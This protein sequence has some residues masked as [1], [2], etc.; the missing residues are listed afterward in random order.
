MHTDRQK[1]RLRVHRRALVH[2]EG[3]KVRLRVH[4]RALVHTEGRK[5]QGRMFGMQ[6]I[7]QLFFEYSAQNATFA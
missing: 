3:R 6:E 5:A 4:R 7:I 1:V 2:T